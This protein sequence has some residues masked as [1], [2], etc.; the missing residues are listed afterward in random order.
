MRMKGDPES[1]MAL[2]KEGIEHARKAGDWRQAVIMSLFLAEI[3]AEVRPDLAGPILPAPH[4]PI[5]ITVLP[6][7]TTTIQPGA[8]DAHGARRHRP[9]TPATAQHS[10]PGCDCPA[11]RQRSPAPGRC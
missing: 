1:S 7:D 2:Y 5:R 6:V 11:P 4:T 9:V 10:G 8:I 3:T